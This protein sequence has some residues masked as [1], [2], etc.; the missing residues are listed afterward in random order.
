MT[1]N[2]PWDIPRRFFRLR[3]FDGRNSVKEN[4]I[5]S[6]LDI[7]AKVTFN[8]TATVSG[9]VNEANITINGLTRDKMNFLSTSTTTWT[10]RQIKNS[11][12]IEA[13][14]EEAR[15]IIFVGAIVEAVPSLV[16]ADYSIAMKCLSYFPEMLNSVKSYSFPGKV[17]VLEIANRFASDAGFVFRNGLGVETI[18]ISDYRCENKSIIDNIRYLARMTGLEIWVSDG[19]LNIK[20]PGEEMPQVKVL[21]ISPRNMIGSPQPTNVGCNVQIRMNPSVQTGQQVSMETLKFPELNRE[22][23][24][25]QTISHTGDTWGNDW[26]THLVLQRKGLYAD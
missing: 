22:G 23:Y 2:I 11:L 14:Y 9:A 25:I 6:D 12:Q 16:N 18:M 10:T 13:G 4:K 15:G 24:V 8:T 5:L 7:R 20:R 26:A 19:R 1:K 3:L 21:K 17:Y